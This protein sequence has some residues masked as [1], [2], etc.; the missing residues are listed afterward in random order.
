M[1]RSKFPKTSLASFFNEQIGYCRKS[2]FYGTA[3]NYSRTLDSFMNFTGNRDL[4]FSAVD[5]NLVLDYEKWLF[6]RG[7]ARNSTSFYMRN[8]RAVYNKAVKRNLTRQ[9]HP[10]ED[11][12]TGVDR[13]GKR[14][15]DERVIL[16]LLKLDLMS[17]KSLALTRDLF[18]FSYCARGMSFVDI[19][20]LKKS[21]ISSGT[22]SYVR[23]KTG[24][25]LVIGIEPCI[26]RIIDRYSA[27]GSGPYVFPV[28]TSSDPETAYRQYQT[29]LSYHNRKLKRLGEAIGENLSLSSYTA[30]H[31][32]ATAARRH[33]VPISVISEGM[34]HSSEK[35]TRIYLAALEN[36]VIDE[37][38]RGILGILNCAGA[39]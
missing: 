5:S 29:A 19:A 3:R 37:A 31:T 11:V 7:L 23:R 9:N 28:I 36:S 17:S 14:A 10:F 30:R 33:N 8:L 18:V 38:N 27:S 16:S 21:D 15:V 25:R 20:F 4:S 2:G 1:T 34:G 26:R 32:W 35:T 22:I 6:S 13:T 24:Q 39:W 12:Y